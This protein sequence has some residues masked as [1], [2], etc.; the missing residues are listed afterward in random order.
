VKVGVAY[1][2]NINKVRD[3]LNVV[4]EKNMR[5]LDDPPPLFIFLG[6]GDSSQDIQFSVWARRENFLELRNTMQIDIKEAFDAAGIEIPVPHRSLYTG[7]VTHPF[8]IRIVGAA[9][10][11]A[12]ADGERRDGE[13]ATPTPE[14]AT[15]APRLP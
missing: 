2:E 15:G 12:P 1:K 13:G 9:P 4:A 14:D 6:F 7:E 8:P 5:C 3:V 10:E 11:P